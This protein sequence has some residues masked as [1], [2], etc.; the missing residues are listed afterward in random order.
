MIPPPAIAP[1]LSAEECGL[2]DEL[3]L[4]KPILRT[5]ELMVEIGLAQNVR[6]TSV[7]VVVLWVV[8]LLI[9]VRVVIVDDTAV[10]IG[11]VGQE[12]DEREVLVSG[13]GVA[14]EDDVLTT[15]A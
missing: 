10:G 3:L 9:F 5:V 6:V 1:L 2:P 13:Q 11:P 15:K 12:V 14:D 7:D 4:P 8:T